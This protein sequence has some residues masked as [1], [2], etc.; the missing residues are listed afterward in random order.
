MNTKIERFAKY[1]EICQRV[2]ICRK[3][4]FQLLV[5]TECQQVAFE[6]ILNSNISEQ[7]LEY[8][9]TQLKNSTIN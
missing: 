9:V 8:T 7:I 5:V 3:N 4:L 2:K 6:L 1:F